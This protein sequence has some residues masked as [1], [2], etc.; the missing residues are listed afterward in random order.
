MAA[1]KKSNPELERAMRDSL[2]AYAAGDKRFFGYLSSDVRVYS[3][4]SAEPIVGRKAFE[5][6][7]APTFQTKRKVSILKKDI[8]L[9]DRQAVLSQTL[10][11]TVDGVDSF[12][13]QTVIW[14]QSD[15]GEW[16]M[17]HIHNALVGQPVLSGKTPKTANA[18]RV[19]N[20]RIATV[21]ATLGV[22]Q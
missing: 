6:A 13:R 9:S 21:A 12:M 5:S 4:N 10:Q 2:K 16:Q 19:L 1:S 14:E 8:Q 15:K 3:L 22:A 18:V 20:E 17:S 7:F 11:V